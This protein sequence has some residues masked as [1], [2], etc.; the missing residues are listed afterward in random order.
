[1][2]SQ[3]ETLLDLARRHVREGE[4]RLAQ[5][6]ALVARFERDQ[7]ADPGEIAPS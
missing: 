6:E 2:T 3:P 4:A 1:M 7:R 5:Q